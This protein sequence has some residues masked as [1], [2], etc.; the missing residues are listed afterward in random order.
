MMPWSPRAG[1][2]VRPPE[3]RSSHFPNQGRRH[4]EQEAP[5]RRAKQG[6]LWQ[7]QAGA[8]GRSENLWA[9]GMQYQRGVGHRAKS[10]LCS[11][12]RVLHLTPPLQASSL[13]S[14]REHWTRGVESQL[15]PCLALCSWGSSLC[16][17]CFLYICHTGCFCHTAYCHT[18]YCYTGCCCYTRCYC[19]MVYYWS[20]AQGEALLMQALSQLT[21]TCA[22]EEAGRLDR[23]AWP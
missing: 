21:H 19:H 9:L 8:E 15:C 7:G 20:Q 11:G 23:F 13:A 10:H 3:G 14:D 18:L 17:P 22:P 1:A 6:T 12:G 2:Q 5:C 16:W 4:P